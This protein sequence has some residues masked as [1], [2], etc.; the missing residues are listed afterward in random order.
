MEELADEP[1]LDLGRQFQLMQS[2]TDVDKESWEMHE[3]LKH[4][5]ERLG[6]ERE[7]LVDEVDDM[8]QGY[9]RCPS[10]DIREI[11]S[12][13]VVDLETAGQWDEELDCAKMVELNPAN[14]LNT[15]EV[16]SLRIFMCF[17]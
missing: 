14:N 1:N 13:P 11:S 8:D 4:M 6:E 12:S 10:A 16:R 5:E 3:I 7:M 15:E 9:E 2:E 17:L